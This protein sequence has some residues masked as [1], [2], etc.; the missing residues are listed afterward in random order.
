MALIKC[1]KCGKEISDKSKNCIH[2]KAKVPRQQKLK[3][4]TIITYIILTI[5][6]IITLGIILY[7]S[8]FSSSNKNK[9]LKLIN[10]QILYYNCGSDVELC[11][12][13]FNNDKVTINYIKYD[14]NGGHVTANDYNW[15]VDNNNITI[16]DDLKIP[17][18]IENNNIT[19]DKNAYFT[20]EEIQKGIQGYW[21]LDNTTY[22]L[23]QIIKGKVNIYIN[24]NNITYQDATQSKYDPNEYF[25]SGPEEKT[26]TLEN[27]QIQIDSDAANSPYYFN[28]IEGEVK[29]L[30]YY[31]VME[32]TDSLPDVN[33]YKF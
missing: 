22:V 7:L 9:V 2:C 30:Y 13:I 32:R 28:I 17:Y 8:L 5:L 23:G 25:Y 12:A 26:Y 4:K 27:G 16:N 10:K 31:K 3:K 33:S 29:V 1:P 11:Q 14:G 18:N 20:P 24:G 15:N 21:K 19:F 6:I